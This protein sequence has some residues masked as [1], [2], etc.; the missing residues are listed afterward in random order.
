MKL[1]FMPV[2]EYDPKQD[3]PKVLGYPSDDKK[4]TP[5][6]VQVYMYREEGWVKLRG[7]QWRETEPPYYFCDVPDVVR[8]KYRKPSLE[9]IE[10]LDIVTAMQ[11]AKR[12]DKMQKEL[13]EFVKEYLRKEFY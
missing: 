7:K 8:V 4:L 3:N 10:S 1:H 11:Y 13:T 2:F 9:K 6:L 12:D 5:S